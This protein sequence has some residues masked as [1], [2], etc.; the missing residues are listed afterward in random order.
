MSLAALR[1]D[2]P[3]HGGI[4]TEVEAGDEGRINSLKN[5]GMENQKKTG[6][7]LG[8]S[9]LWTILLGHLPIS[10]CH[11]E[12]SMISCH[13]ETNTVDSS[14]NVGQHYIH[15]AWG[16]PMLDSIVRSSSEQKQ[17]VAPTW[18]SPP[19]SSQT[20]SGINPSCKKLHPILHPKFQSSLIHGVR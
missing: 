6:H 11:Y 14:K 16:E 18:S 3:Q 20:S 8:K 1:P 4:G 19:K 7:F 17:P 2:G 10:Q 9:S 12:Y 5:H 13:N 15:N